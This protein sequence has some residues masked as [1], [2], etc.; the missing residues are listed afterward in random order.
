[1]VKSAIHSIIYRIG[2]NKQKER[3]TKTTTEKSASAF[4]E[5]FVKE[6]D[7]MHIEESEKNAPQ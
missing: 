1:M 3:K 4:R 5:K 2:T 7:E 6:T